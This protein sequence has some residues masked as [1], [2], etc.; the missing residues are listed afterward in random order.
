MYG[1]GKRSV[2]SVFLVGGGVKYNSLCFF[3]LYQAIILERRIILK[4]DCHLKIEVHFILFIFKVVIWLNQNFLLPE[5]TNIQNAPFQ[6]CF[7]SLRNGGQLY[8]KI[9]LSGEVTFTVTGIDFLWTVDHS[10]Q[11]EVGGTS[12]KVI[13]PCVST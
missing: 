13:K 2:I 3:S 6:V 5:D 7:T 1:V 10:V 8:I 12:L 9:K 11:S 4:N